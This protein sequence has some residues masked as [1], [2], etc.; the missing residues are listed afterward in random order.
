MPTRAQLE[1]LL[2]SDPDDTFLL[3]A[4]AKACAGEGDVET[5]LQQFDEVLKRDA[6]H[7]PAYFQKG[8][9]LAEQGRTA[10]A[11]VILTQGIAVARDVGDDHAEAEMQGFLEMLE[12]E[13]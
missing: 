12:S 2:E 10:E 1:A 9:V 11:R 4:H 5:A 13:P 3:Y 8:Q 6:R 7:V